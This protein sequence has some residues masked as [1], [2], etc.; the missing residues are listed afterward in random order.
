MDFNKALEKKYG[1][2][3]YIVL[4]EVRNTT[5]YSGKSRYADALV[6]QM[7]PSRGLS[8]IGY[9]FKKSRSDWLK[10]L[11]NP[12][13]AD[14]FFPYCHEWYLLTANKNDIAKKEE[15]PEPWGWQYLTTTGKIR[16]AKK[17]VKNDNPILD[18]GFIFSV[19]RNLQ[20]VER[21]DVQKLLSDS[22]R[23]GKESV[24]DD[25]KSDREMLDLERRGYEKDKAELDKLKRALGLHSWNNEPVIRRFSNFF[26]QDLPKLIQFS[27]VIDNHKKSVNDFESTFKELVD[28]V[29]E[30]DES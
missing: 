22:Y 4:T 26:R 13:K 15:I 24:S 10:E 29:R 21:D 11:R 18:Y 30:I 16:S 19:F 20:H 12:S 3:G 27:R 23:R 17:P 5:G 25:L 9:E 14:S 1:D 28:F 8:V 2:D 6:F 7:Y